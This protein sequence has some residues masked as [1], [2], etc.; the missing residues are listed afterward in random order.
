[1]YDTCIYKYWI[2]LCAIYM[3]YKPEY[4]IVEMMITTLVIQY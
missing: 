4:D 3:L 2:Y 1:M